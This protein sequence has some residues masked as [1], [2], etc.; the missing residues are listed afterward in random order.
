M[1]A[2]EF[3]VVIADDAPNIRDRLEGLLQA[4]AGVSVVAV[5]CDGDEALAALRD[6]KPDLVVLDIRMPKRGGFDVLEFMRAH[7]P[8]TKAVVCTNYPYPQY[9]KRA[10]ELGAVEFID[11]GKDLSTVPDVVRRVLNLE[12]A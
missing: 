8:N 2:A 3:S 1:G 4:I 6:H 5:A 10:A 12:G 11:K 7:S 9:R